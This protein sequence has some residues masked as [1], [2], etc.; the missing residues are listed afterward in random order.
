MSNQEAFVY[1]WTDH[2][3]NMLYVGYHK[4]KNINKIGNIGAMKRWH[5]DNCKLRKKN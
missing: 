5:F 3:T 4:H 2:K 1:C